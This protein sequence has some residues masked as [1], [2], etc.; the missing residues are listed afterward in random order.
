MTACCS[1][2]LGSTAVNGLT[3]VK[4]SDAAGAVS[5]GDTMIYTI[6]VSNNDATAHSDVTVTDYM[7][8]GARYVS[9]SVNVVQ[10]PVRYT[11][12]VFNTT[13][14]FIVPAGVSNVTV[15]AWGAGGG[16]GKA[17]AGDNNGGGGGGGGGYARGSYAVTA[18]T[19][20]A[21]TV[22]IGG[23]AATAGGASWFGTVDTLFA[24]GGGAG[25]IGA[26][27]GAGGSANIGNQA[28]YNGGNG[29]GGAE[30]GNKR[31]RRG[32]GGG[33]A[34]TSAANGG[35]G[36]AG[37][38]DGTGGAGGAGGG[39]GGQG[40]YGTSDGAAGNAVGGGGGGGGYEGIGGAGANGRVV[41]TYLL[42]GSHGDPPSLASGWRLDPGSTLTIT[43]S[44]LVDDPCTKTQ[45]VNTASVT[46]AQQTAVLRASVTNKLASADL[47]VEKSVNYGTPTV[48]ALLDYTVVVLNGGPHEATGVEVTDR[49]PD[50]LSYSNATPSQ[51]TYDVVSGI[52]TVGKL[53]VGEKA[54]LVLQAVLTNDDAYAGMGITNWARISGRKQIDL[55]PENNSAH[56][57]IMPQPTWALISAFRGEAV[58]GGVRVEW[59]TGAE[60]G[61]I[62]FN[63]HRFNEETGAWDPV[64]QELLVGL[65]A[66]P[67]GGSYGLVDTRAEAGR[68]S[69]YRLEE[70][71]ADGTRRWYGPFEVCA[72][73]PARGGVRSYPA[74]GRKVRSGTVLGYERTPRVSEFSQE[75]RA[76]SAAKS[77]PTRML[78]A[79]SAA[80]GRPGGGSGSS[81]TPALKVLVSENGVYYLDAVVLASRMGVTP[82]EVISWISSRELAIESRGVACAYVPAP[83]GLYFYGQVPDSQYTS[84]NVYWV[85]RAEGTF[86]AME[87][88]TPVSPQSGG[89]FADVLHIEKDWIEVTA[90][91]QDPASD[92]W[93]WNY[94]I[95]GTSTQYALVPP[96][97]ASYEGDAALVVRLLGATT[98]GMAREHH[99]QVLLNGALVGE[100][101]WEGIGEKIF[102]NT[103]SHA[104]LAAGVNTVTV[105][106]LK[107]VDVPFSVIYVDAFDLHYKRFY[108]AVN[109]QLLLRGDGNAVV[110]VSGFSGSDIRVLNVSDP[111]RPVVRDGV[112]VDF[113]DGSWRASFSP[114]P[115]ASYQVFAAGSG[116][117]PAS[118]AADTPS[119]LRDRT[120][121][122]DY[123]VITVPQ[124]QAA[125]QALA[126]YRQGKGLSSKVVLLEDIYDEFNAGLSEPP[127]IRTF[128]QHAA[129]AW[130]IAPR[131]V[132]LA[133][134]GSYDYLNR[135][136]T[137]D[138]LVPAM[139]V[140][141]PHGLFASDNWYADLDDDSL[142][143]LA[144]GR[145]PALTGAELD[146]LVGKV[147]EYENGEGGRWRQDVL[148]AADNPDAG[149]NFPGSCDR[150]GRL[151]PAD[152][153]TQKIYLSAQ[154]SRDVRAE[155]LGAVN[156]GLALLNYFGHGGL[157]TMASEQLF[158]SADAA[159]LTNGCRRPVVVTLS[160]LIGQYALP[161]YDC[162]AEALMLAPGGAAA[163]WA[164]SGLSLN[165][166]AMRLA[167]SF[168]RAIFDGEGVLGS[169][170]IKSLRQCRGRSPRPDA[171]RVYNLLGDPAMKLKG[172]AFAGP[173][174]TLESWQNECFSSD[175]LADPE[176]G[177]L[178]ADP[179]GDGVE[180]L[181]EYAMGWNPHEADGD[182][183]LSIHG[184]WALDVNGLGE[185]HVPYRRRTGVEDVNFQLQF[186]TDA[187][188]WFA[189]D[190]FVQDMVVTDNGDGLT[191]T[192]WTCLSIPSSQPQQRLFVRLVVSR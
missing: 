126:D 118:I 183:G 53:A 88:G 105:R 129:S 77:A 30:N 128:L 54:T 100:A 21:V 72:E 85:S 136:G 44:V 144:I 27:V 186:S 62:G 14:S 52:W 150:I 4:T 172:T 98:V 64:N 175:A 102:T 83:E 3:V 134:E 56:A 50:G 23:A 159:G 9:A 120:N 11:T 25:G 24:A 104:L 78:A 167:D 146:L 122:A 187:V 143:E 110:T 59:E 94:L 158:T 92:Y 180:N 101:S 127:A 157:D 31:F 19:T 95:S 160:C 174:L 79:N 176:V 182:S 60:V 66:A 171:M 86:A 130:A 152:Y 145:L 185:A 165:C 132:V 135:K 42:N 20:Q 82:E 169:A 17:V 33:A 48:G 32:G 90:G 89:S 8:E 115:D 147:I 181:M 184:P 177:G 75:R 49:L 15:E 65:L 37:G 119:D 41:I 63:L 91:R 112:T 148:L 190:A 16:G 6:I 173:T 97:L 12:V 188:N 81:S 13:A 67:Q 35:N 5:F 153:F 106:A 55:M 84:N 179:D 7:P 161:G 26:A 189:S 113:S 47:A 71:E 22:G 121:A 156:R 131:Y 99:V 109:D 2:L 70:V 133:G 162:L 103:F 96:G 164:P 166:R 93:Y 192:V 28:T 137:G 51:G 46:T 116:R 58:E 139:M 154:D 191:E 178:G 125:V 138:N 168:Y 76:R 117:V 43:F 140:A 45:I 39:A 69:V 142:P 29:G 1:L 61:T 149:G 40:N 38:P 18:G 108:Q 107:D 10:A 114:A 73:A 170:I 68:K 124:L 57:D 87:T 36:Q 155:F 163:V 141:T 123:V 111:L 80:G 74:P 34:A 151:M